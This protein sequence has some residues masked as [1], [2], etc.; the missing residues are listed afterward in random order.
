MGLRTVAAPKQRTRG[1]LPN[2]AQCVF[3]HE[4]LDESHHM[5]LIGAISAA[6]TA[7]HE[8]LEHVVALVA[9]V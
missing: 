5:N 7:S 1:A 2:L 4:R 8:V 3:A 9:T 6:C